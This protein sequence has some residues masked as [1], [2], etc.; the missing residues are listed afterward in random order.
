MPVYRHPS[1]RFFRFIYFINPLA[2]W[3]DFAIFAF[4]LLMMNQL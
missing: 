2:V 1:V 3:E 4:R